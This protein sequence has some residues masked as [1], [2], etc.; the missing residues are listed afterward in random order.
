MSEEFIIE[1]CSPTLAGLKTGNM[2]STKITKDTDINSEVR[3][4]NAVLRDKGLRVIPLRRS[5]ERALIY[6]YR[7]DHLKKDLN[8]PKALSI[9]KNKGY[10][11]ESPE[12]CIVQ[13]I[14]HLKCD[15]SFPHE[16]GLFL[17]YPPSDVASFMNNPRCGVRCSGCWKA[18]SDPKKA[19]DTF[20]RYRKCTRVYKEMNKKGRTLSQLTVMSR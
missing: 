12:C 18:Y 15:D 5:D 9:L 19:E 3:E 20:N 11:L 17:G 16:I 8:D 2:F 7:P 1:Y 10:S 4:L 13:L 6:V 14:K